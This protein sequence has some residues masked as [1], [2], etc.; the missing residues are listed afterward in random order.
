M[1]EAWS[2]RAAA[3]GQAPGHRTAQLEGSRRLRELHGEGR[4]TR[5]P[6][7]E[8]GAGGRGGGTALLQGQGHH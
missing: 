3:L 6:H 1:G 2:S 8:A 7:R 4:A 5:R